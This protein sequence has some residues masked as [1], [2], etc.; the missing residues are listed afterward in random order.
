MFNTLKLPH[1]MVDARDSQLHQDYTI[2]SEKIR[3]LSESQLVAFGLKSYLFCILQK[4]KINSLEIATGSFFKTSELKC[5]L[6]ASVLKCA[7]C[8]LPSFWALVQIPS[9]EKWV[10]SSENRP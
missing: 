1:S 2:D 7:M 10:K 5:R 6:C 4:S 8:G 9:G 3:L